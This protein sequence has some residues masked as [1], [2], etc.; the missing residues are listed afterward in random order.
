MHLGIRKLAI[1]YNDIAII[2]SGIGF[3]SPEKVNIDL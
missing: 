2:H 3:H 1:D